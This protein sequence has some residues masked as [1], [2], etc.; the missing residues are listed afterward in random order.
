MIFWRKLDRALARHTRRRRH[1]GRFLPR[2]VRICVLPRGRTGSQRQRRRDGARQRHNLADLHHTQWKLLLRMQPARCLRSC[3]VAGTRTRCMRPHLLQPRSVGGSARLRFLRRQQ[4]TL[5]AFAERNRRNAGPPR[6]RARER[7]NLRTLCRD[8]LHALSGCKWAANLARRG[9]SCTETALR[10]RSCFI[11]RHA[12]SHYS[13]FRAPR[14]SH[15]TCS[16]HGFAA[17]QAV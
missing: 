17:K 13:R 9:Q 12:L 2:S 1:G 15:T 10:S 8:N 14:R 6:E 4:H 7:D 3:V 5:Q 16:P 11:S